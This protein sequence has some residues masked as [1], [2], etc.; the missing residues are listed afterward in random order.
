MSQ[1]CVDSQSFVANRLDVQLGSGV[2]THSTLR[3]S[4]PPTTYTHTL[5]HSLTHS[6]SHSVLLWNLVHLQLLAAPPCLSIF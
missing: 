1:H 3:H 2:P 6:S 4:T 5:T